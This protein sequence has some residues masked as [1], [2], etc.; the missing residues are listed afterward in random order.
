MNLKRSSRVAPHSVTR[1]AASGAFR[2]IS[3]D[4]LTGSLETASSGSITRRISAA[5]PPRIQCIVRK[6]ISWYRRTYG[7]GSR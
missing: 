2:V 3:S 6:N 4:R 7:A 5:Q 1:G